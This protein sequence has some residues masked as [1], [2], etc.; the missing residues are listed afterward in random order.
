MTHKLVIT[1][2]VDCTITT[3][4]VEGGTVEYV[5]YASFPEPVCCQIDYPMALVAKCDA[6]VYRN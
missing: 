3:C 1:Y 4:T 2:D 5:R 6:L